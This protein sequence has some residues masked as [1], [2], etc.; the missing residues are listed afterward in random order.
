MWEVWWKILD[1]RS[2]HDWWTS[3]VLSTQWVCIQ[4]GGETSK[5]FFW[6]F[7][8]QNLGKKIH[9]F[10][11]SLLNWWLKHHP[12]CELSNQFYLKFNLSSWR[13]EPSE[14]I[15]WY[16]GHSHGKRSLKKNMFVCP[17][18]IF[19][20]F[21]YKPTFFFPESKF[22]TGRIFKPI[23]ILTILKCVTILKPSE[24]TVPNQHK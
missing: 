4:L 5:F 16:A 8:C 18:D 19:G 15:L 24:L 23:R 6:I 12:L 20:L 21:S 11:Q 22:S 9:H 10:D 1:V 13:S 2:S 17:L 7:W 14:I 3:I